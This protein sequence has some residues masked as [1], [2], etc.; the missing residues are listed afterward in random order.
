MMKNNS[1][2][3]LE[4]LRQEKEIV[5]RECAESEERLA[6]HWSHFKD[7]AGSLIFY[8]AINSIMKG[9]GFGGKKESEDK[10][11]TRSNSLVNGLLSSLTTYYPLIW[12]MVQPMLIRFAMRKI[13]SIF[14]RKKKKRKD[15]DD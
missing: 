9:F 5:R 14:S 6:D 8:S 2:S 1:I 13:K 7:N 4:E 11:E 3:P 10:P 12:D 15:D